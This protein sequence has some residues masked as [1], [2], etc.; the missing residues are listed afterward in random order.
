MQND[1]HQSPM[2]YE[3]AIKRA[4]IIQK[5]RDFFKARKVLEVDT[6]IM[7]HG[8]P[9]DCH[10][11]VFS[12][13]YHPAGVRKQAGSETVYLRPSPEFHM[14]RLLASGYRDIFQIGKVF[15][16]GELGRLHNPEFTMLE[17]YRKNK[18][19]S[20]CMDETAALVTAVLG[21]KKIVKKKYA[22][23]FKEAT[24]IDPLSTDTQTVINC[25]TAQGK[26]HPEFATL[27]DALQF[28]MAELVEPGFPADAL[29]IVHH[30]PADQAVLAMLEPDDPRVARRF[31][32][33]CGGCELANGFEE[34][35]DWKENE[36]RQHEEN[37]RRAAA[38][39]ETL[40]VD[41]LFIDALRKGLP[42]CSG[43]ALG[44]DRLI[45]LALKKQTIDEVIPFTWEKS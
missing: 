39:K 22:E 20:D 14:K 38:G 40:P 13:E 8:T 26:T 17:W 45:M 30:Y 11:D 42:P 10:I 6:P 35:V 9:T 12:A 3:T 29:V 44:L 34:L 24:G 19:M 1:N 4:E 16:N 33:Y 5:I 41:R 43:V 2:N 37:A 25:C 21:K 23:I 28:A 18:S 32:A 27:T 36:R 7:S 31:E 15:R